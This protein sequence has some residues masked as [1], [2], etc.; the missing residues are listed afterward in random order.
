MQM[1][2]REL[3]RLSVPCLLTREPGGTLFGERV[4]RILLRDDA[5]EREPVAE[6]LLYL[7]DRYQH[8][9]EVVEPALESGLH[10]ISDR[11]H[12]ATLAYQGYARGIG[13][14]LIDQLGAALQLRQPDLTLV[15][16]VDVAVSLKRAR[17]RNRSQRSQQWGR[18]ESETAIFHRNVLQGYRLLA[19]RAAG[20]IRFLDGSGTPDQVFGKIKAALY[21]AGILDHPRETL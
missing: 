19:Q 7:A 2:E 5:V 20:R 11:Y 14:E 3:K 8:L 6:L 21:Q 17:Q 16:N 13:F 4:R 12:D 9:K 1:L 18:F 10:V 15:L